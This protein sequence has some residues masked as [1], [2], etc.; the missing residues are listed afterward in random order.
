M[1]ADL[2]HADRNAQVF[3][4]CECVVGTLNVER[5]DESL[6]YWL[7]H[8]VFSLA[9]LSQSLAFEY[10][11]SDRQRLRLTKQSRSDL[12]GFGLSVNA[13]ST[14]IP[15]AKTI[16][17]QNNH[18]VCCAVGCIAEE[19]VCIQGRRDRSR[20]RQRGCVAVETVVGNTDSA[21]GGGIHGG[22]IA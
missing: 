22:F 10:V 9:D 17:F 12:D 6:L 2:E 1:H 3:E 8:P 7:V 19:L 20:S 18:C 13:V 5:N 15:I 11:A 16:L 14:S 4:Y 21:T